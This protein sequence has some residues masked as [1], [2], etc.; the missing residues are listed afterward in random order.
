MKPEYK[1]LLIVQSAEEC[2]AFRSHLQK[3]ERFKFH[4]FEAGDA[5]SGLETLQK[6]NP[7]LVLLDEN[8]PDTSASKILEKLNTVS[9]GKNL[10]VILLLDKSDE[11][12]AEYAIKSG[13]QDFYFKDRGNGFELR[14]KVENEIE[15]IALRRE[16]ENKHTHNLEHQFHDTFYSL[17]EK[18]PF[19]I[20]IVDED[21]RIAQI[22]PSCNKAFN[23]IEP[24]IGRDFAEVLGIIWAES[25]ASEIEERFRNTLATGESYHSYV[26]SGQREN[27]SDTESYDWKI[28]RVILPDGTFGVVAY[29][30][31]LTD[32][33][34]IE[35][36][37][38]ESE[39]N[40]RVLFESIDEGFM[41][42]DVIFDDHNKPSDFTFA[43]ANPSFWRLSGLSESMIGKTAL[44]AIPGLEDFWLETYSRVASTGKSIR[45]ENY[46]EE[47]SRWFDVYASRV[48]GE[49]SNRVAIVFN[50][51]T[52]RKT[53]EQERERLLEMEKDARRIAEEN[54]RAKDDFLTML[55]HEL[56]APLNA[57]YGWTQIL[58][59]GESE[60]DK[61]K[62]K[63]AI[64]VIDRNV[65][66]QSA[67]IEDLLDVS[68][69]ITNKMQLEP[70]IV[71][72]T[73]SVQTAIKAISPAAEKK[74]LTVKLKIDTDADEV[75]GD[76][77]RL[78]QIIDNLLTNA[79][80][81]TPQDG[82]INVALERSGDGDKLK[83]SIEDN[84]IGI[85][86]EILPYVFDRFS[87]GD[88]GSK[89]KYGG[90]GLGLAI[91]K[92]LVSLHDGNV[93]AHSDGDGKGALF[94]VEFPLALD[95]AKKQTTS[96]PV[97]VQS[98]SADVQS[99]RQ[100]KSLAGKRILLVDDDR[101]VLNFLSL[102]IR[103]EDAEVTCC[104]LASEALEKIKTKNFDLMISDL[105]MEPMDGF[106]LIR[107]IRAEQGEYFQ[108]LPA[109]AL[110]GYVSAQDRELALA[111]GFQNHI[112]KP[113]KLDN[114]LT[115]IS[116]LL[117]K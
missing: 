72:L 35:K 82:E 110:T 73:S 34:N 33:K 8:L 115:I 113:V 61:D 91:V 68:R 64:Q 30:Y 5:A 11:A 76:R 79:V 100:E 3:S 90:L 89:R 2:S 16:L 39:E 7:E 41:I 17:V 94:T 66:L 97:D 4:L 116:G 14:Q 1:I 74:S 104:N 84:G 108:K 117:E 45:F 37:L 40:Y 54:N 62:V 26:I 24:I 13:A 38:R 42:V 53:V 78:R 36:A 9:S 25:I 15:K 87:Q 92:H 81:F 32:L 70:S 27:I 71:P 99:V 10:S 85:N 107:Q 114:L 75:F 12:S 22:S 47:L 109:I 19:G 48:G 69:I 56:R 98:A 23:N 29:F 55:S 18:S 60:L 102:V 103:E 50:N 77:Y 28:E 20:Y 44:E 31:D 93:S 86:P 67:L 51:V 80:K 49:E 101:D 106:D 52:A 105:G 88:G 96:A 95:S 43:Q 63:E 46:A 57:I 58:Q 6:E 111:A 65:R 21:F 59:N 112:A 83:L